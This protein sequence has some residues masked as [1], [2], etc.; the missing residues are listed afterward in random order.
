VGVFIVFGEQL[1]IKIAFGRQD[2]KEVVWT[3]SSRSEI[4]AV[5]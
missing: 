2:A 1:V 5:S 3:F 4:H